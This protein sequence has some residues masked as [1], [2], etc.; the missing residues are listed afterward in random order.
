MGTYNRCTKIRLK[1]LN[2]LWK[3]EKCQDP[4]GGIFFL[5]H[6][7]HVIRNEA[8][9]CG[10]CVVTGWYIQT[11]WTSQWHG[12]RLARMWRRVWVVLHCTL[13]FAWALG[14]GPLKWRPWFKDLL[15]PLTLVYSHKLFFI[16]LL[17]VLCVCATLQAVVNA[18]KYTTLSQK[19]TLWTLKLGPFF[20]TQ[21]SILVPLGRSVLWNTFSTCIFRVKQEAKLSLG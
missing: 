19:T 20:E 17:C 7:V 13:F 4:S 18:T 10:N 21:C 12:R 9:N 5:T 14:D 11:A 2:R 8:S 3:T 15:I 1:I 16:C 6:T